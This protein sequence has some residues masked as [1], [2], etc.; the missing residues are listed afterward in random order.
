VRD[1]LTSLEVPKNYKVCGSVSIGYAAD[2]KP[3]EK[4]LRKNVVTIIK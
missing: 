2:I 1:I 3:K 4:I